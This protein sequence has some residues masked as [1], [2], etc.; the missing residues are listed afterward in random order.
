MVAF[1]LPDPDDSDDSNTES[2]P[3]VH[4]HRELDGLAALL[5]DAIATL[6]RLM[7]G[8]PGISTEVQLATATC[9]LRALGIMDPPPPPPPLPDDDDEV[10]R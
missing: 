7:A 3:G 1:A 10:F 8:G 5:P 2:N 6:R 9:V 4:I